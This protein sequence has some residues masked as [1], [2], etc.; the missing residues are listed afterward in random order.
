[1]SA[2]ALQTAVMECQAAQQQLE[3]SL[4]EKEAL[5]KHTAEAQQ[6]QEK[7][8]FTKVRGTFSVGVCQL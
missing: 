4:A 3:R 1:M 2:A 7:L 8:L 5:L 6:E